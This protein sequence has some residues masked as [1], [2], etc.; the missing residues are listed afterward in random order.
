MDQEIKQVSNRLN[1]K[2][3]HL[4]SEDSR[5]ELRTERIKLEELL[6]TIERRPDLGVGQIIS[7]TRRNE[8]GAEYEDGGWRID[9]LTGDG[10]VFLIKLEEGA[11]KYL[12]LKEVIKGH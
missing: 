12:P 4:Q 3:D 7:I 6:L 2:L 8:G 10:K 1:I 5:E 11:S 9:H